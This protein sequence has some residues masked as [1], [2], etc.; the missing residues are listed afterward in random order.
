M[1][2]IAH[3]TF[4]LLFKTPHRHLA[5]MAGIFLLLILSACQPQQG[6]YTLGL[7]SAADSQSLP[8]GSLVLGAEQ[9][10]GYELAGKAV[11][12]LFRLSLKSESTSPDEVQV[13]VRGMVENTNP[14]VV[15]LVGATT[16]AGTTRT[17]ALANFFNLPM[18]VPSAIG[19]NLL[20]SNNLWAFRL[21]APGSA[22]AAYLFDTVLTRQV[23]S[24]LTTGDEFSVPLSLGIFYE[25]NTFGESTAVET[26]KYA[27]AQEIEIGYYGHFDPDAPDKARLVQAFSAM[28]EAGV[29]LVY[30]VASNPDA[31]QIIVSAFREFFVPGDAPLLLGQSGGFATHQFLQSPEASGVFILRQQIVTDRCPDGIETL[32]EAQ[33]YAA[34][35]LLSFSIEQ[36]G[37]QLGA[38][39]NPTLTDQREAVRDSLKASSLNLPCLGLTSFDNSGQNKN[40]QFEF[41]YAA[42]TAPRLIA[43]EKLTEALAPK[44]N[45]DPFE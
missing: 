5:A 44:L 9:K 25:Q 11:D 35:Q 26:A 18:V 12:G 19:D 32:V 24:G 3:N 4:R 8:A 33:A 17:A 31:A 15:A 1:S 36:S 30:I 45:R 38:K 34:I 42:N 23:I 37:D 39:D 28:Q 20:P 14:P 6:T 13:T 22:H 40:L 10:T 2:T 43:A 7:L 27:M 41:L 16:N 21:S 29:H